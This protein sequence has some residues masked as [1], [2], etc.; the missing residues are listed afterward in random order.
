MS[1]PLFRP[2]TVYIEKEIRDL[3]MTQEILIRL[4]RVDFRLIDNAREVK[5]TTEITPAKKALIL[6]R[7][8]PDEPLKEFATMSHSTGR[9][10]YSLNLISNCHLEC[11]YCILQS[12]LANNPIITVFTNLE[13]ILA[14]LATQ[15]EKIP[16]GSVI[17][18]GQIADSLALEELTGLHQHLIPFFGSQDRVRLE[19]KTKSDAV[20]SLLRLPHNGQAVLSWSMAPERIQ[21]DEEYKTAPI[22]KRL[23]AVLRAQAAG[24]P[25]GLHFD[26]IIH[27]IGWEKNYRDLIRTIFSAID[28]NRLAWVSLGTLRFPVRQVRTMQERFPRNRKIFHNLVSTHNRCLHYPERL[29]ESIYRRIRDYLGKYITE[30]KIYLSMEADQEESMH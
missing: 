13:E 30:E 23:E 18:T 17:G 29:R 8:K 2:E 24:Y 1:T 14:R 25:I 6:A 15:M 19:L 16:R 11:S 12:Y 27:H 20:D 5:K 7:F 22:A 3:P 10:T 4:G 21:K 28:P 9:P 26:P